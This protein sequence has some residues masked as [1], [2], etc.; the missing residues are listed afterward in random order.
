MKRKNPKIS[1]GSIYFQSVSTPKMSSHSIEA[2]VIDT[3]PHIDEYHSSAY[4][5]NYKIL[6][7]GD[8]PTEDKNLEV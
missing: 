4:K 2:L 1:K 7:S 3:N 5:E 6:N 8:F